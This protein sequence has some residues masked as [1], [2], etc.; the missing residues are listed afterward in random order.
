MKPQGMIWFNILRVV[1]PLG[2]IW[3]L[4]SPYSA[5]QGLSLFKAGSASTMFYSEP[6]YC[7]TY[8]ICGIVSAVMGARL[9]VNLFR[10]SPRCANCARDVIIASTITHIATAYADYATLPDYFSF[11]SVFIQLLVL[12]LIWVPTCS[13]LKKRF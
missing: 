3:S 8:I 5:I 7:Y 2:A 11:G 1:V 10:K 9:T 6:I 4:F 13:Y 12:Y